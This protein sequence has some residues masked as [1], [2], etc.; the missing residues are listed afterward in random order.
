M[1]KPYFTG[2]V[3]ALVP[4]YSDHAAFAVSEEVGVNLGRGFVNRFGASAILPI[5][6]SNFMQRLLHGAKAEPSW[7][8]SFDF[9]LLDGAPGGG[10]GL[11]AVF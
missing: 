4:F 7:A 8:L 1:Q 5:G 3:S 2:G 9:S 10:L 6:D 11:H